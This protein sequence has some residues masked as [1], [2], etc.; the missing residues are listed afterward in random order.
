M[1]GLLRLCAYKL[2]SAYLCIILA[3][4]PGRS[5]SKRGLGLVK[6]ANIICAGK[7]LEYRKKVWHFVI[8]Y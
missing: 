4:I 8:V 2:F 7:A 5:S 6:E 1:T 3:S